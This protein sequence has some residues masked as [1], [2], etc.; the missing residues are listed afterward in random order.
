MELRY[1]EIFYRVVECGSFSRAAEE[2]H[3]TQPTVS[4]HVKALEDELSTRLLDRLGKTVVPTQAG[5]ILYKFAKEIVRLKEEART[6]LEEFGGRIKGRL[7]IGASTIPGEY[8]LPSII[9]RFRENYP[10][11]IP[12]IR[13]GDT[14]DIYGMVL[15]GEVDIGVVG[16]PLRDKNIVSREFLED[17]LVLVAPRDFERTA[18]T[19]EELL[20][21]PLVQRE[22]G[23]GSRA[24]LEASLRDS[25]ID[26]DDL[27]V[28]G[29]MGSTQA[30]I[31]A[32]SAGMGLAFVSH[33]A[34]RENV[35]QGLLRTVRIDDLRIK[36]NFYIITHRMRSFSPI[37][38][39]FL[40][41]LLN[42]PLKNSITVQTDI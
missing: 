22:M 42:Q 28:V 21:L 11:V 5:R 8:I 16:S 32:V 41:F 20:E 17:E 13:V 18:I 10:D 39:T 12:L 6:S 7:S 3:L 23:S 35:E 1:L 38:R 24:S 30:L 4:I 9:S 37:C 33:L 14:M 2:L 31:R 15:H 26:S 29:E 27:K 25:G 36:R 34:I 40:D 19:K